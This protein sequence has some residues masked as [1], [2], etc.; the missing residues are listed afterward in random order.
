M[1][2]KKMNEISEVNIDEFLAQEEVK[3]AADL[4]RVNE[5][6]KSAKQ[7]KI[8]I[9]VSAVCLIASAIL[10]TAYA[11]GSEYDREK[12]RRYKEAQVLQERAMYEDA[13]DV[14]DKLYGYE[15]SESK[16]TACKVLM[17]SAKEKA[18]YDT[19][20]KSFNN[21]DYYTAASL[22]EK[23]EDYED[24][25]DKAKES[26]Y[27]YGEELMAKA[28]WEKAY[29]AFT[30]A[31]DHSN[32]KLLAAKCKIMK[33]GIGTTVT[34]GKYD[35]DGD[36]SDGNEGL[37]WYV[38][39]KSD[40]QVVLLSRYAIALMPYSEDGTAVPYAQSSVRK[41]VNETFYNEAFTE[42]EKAYIVPTKI[43]DGTNDIEDHA[44]ILTKEMF[45]QLVSNSSTMKAAKATQAAKPNSTYSSRS[46]F[47]WTSSITGERVVCIG[48]NGNVY[49]AGASL[50]YG[51]R[52][53]I[54]ID[55]TK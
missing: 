23:V 51:V 55:V 16:I 37:E 9:I 42:E 8:K 21:K 46:T 52:P 7:T 4:A 6:K 12:D 49:D 15:D 18:T 36:N 31:S 22:F 35:Q 13:I 17:Q 25:K 11:I 54:T 40:T 38:I 20:V 19:A 41:F 43:N 3:L 2:D 50:S 44:V 29:D 53:V 1:D 39:S 33:S 10:S 32:A 34:L 30:E 45:E 5:R 48:T 47:Y 14:Y 24:A 26:Y 28:E 27:K